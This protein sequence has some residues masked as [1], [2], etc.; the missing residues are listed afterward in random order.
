MT[1]TEAA[2]ERI[3]RDHNQGRITW[4]ERA[5]LVRQVQAAAEAHRNVFAVLDEHAKMCGR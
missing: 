2:I 5:Y 3:R 4:D 1:Q